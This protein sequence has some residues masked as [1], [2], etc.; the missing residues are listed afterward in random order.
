[1]Q[2]ANDNWKKMY[3]KFFKILKAWWS[4]V[5]NGDTFK[6]VR[7]WIQTLAAVNFDP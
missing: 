4:S 6:S 3:A 2:I 5:C 1:M 7:L